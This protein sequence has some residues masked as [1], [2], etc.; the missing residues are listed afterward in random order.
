MEESIRKARAI[1]EAMPF[2][3]KFYGSTV[4]IKYGGHAMDNPAMKEKTISD[5]TLMKLVGIR[6]IVVHGGGPHITD[7]MKR[8]G[9]EA[10]FV[11]GHRITDT[12]TM[13]ITEMVSAATSIKISPPA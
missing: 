3:R 12:E 13:D 7:L 5:F 1:M 10:V 11:E 2:I 6:P 9:K 4:V 8:L